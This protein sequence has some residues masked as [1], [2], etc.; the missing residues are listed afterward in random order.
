MPFLAVVVVA[1]SIAGGAQPAPAAHALPDCTDTAWVCGAVH[2]PPSVAGSNTAIAFDPTGNAW[3]S[4]RDQ[5]AQ[6]LMVARYVGVG[7][8]CTNADWTCTMI[9]DP[10]GHDV[11]FETDIAFDTD[12]TAWVSYQDTTTDDLKIAHSVPAGNGYGCVPARADWVCEAVD[13]TRQVGGYTAIGV[14]QGLPV[15]TYWD[16]GQSDLRWAR[17]SAAGR[18]TC[19]QVG[20]NCGIV[21]SGSVG[22]YAN[23][24][25]VDSVD[26][27]WVAYRYS[28]SG[29][30]PKAA[31][32]VVATHVGIGGTGCGK[33]SPEWSCAALTKTGNVGL[34]TGIAFDRADNPWVQFWDNNNLNLA[35]L[36]GTGTPCALASGW[37]CTTIHDEANS[38]GEYGGIAFDATGAAWIAHWGRTAKRAYVARH[39][40]SASG[41]GCGPGGSSDWACSTLDASPDVGAFWMGIAIRPAGTWGTGGP[42]VSYFDRQSGALKVAFLKT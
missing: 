8:T 9:D 42:W 10:P 34:D 3:I 21:D 27:A 32:L 30:G 17:P 1:L 15:V 16:S 35:R 38:V 4:F 41:N 12:G 18:S 6:A 13:T 29:T 39:V 36:G 26:R 37:E 25:A 11:G 19:D 33:G 24:I 20:W 31:K 28:G 2:D 7:G 23:D 14:E 22:A 5:D 40:G